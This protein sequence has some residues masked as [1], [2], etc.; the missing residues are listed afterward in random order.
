MAVWVI[1]L[2]ILITPCV[3]TLLTSMLDARKM[4]NKNYYAS[5][6]HF[7]K[8][9]SC[10]NDWTEE[11]TAATVSSKNKLQS[12]FGEKLFDRFSA[13]HLFW[14][15]L[16]RPGIAS[17]FY[18][19]TSIDQLLVVVLASNVDVIGVA[20]SK[21]KKKVSNSWDYLLQCYPL[22]EARVPER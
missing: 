22:R 6:L 9:W 4:V 10:P 11:I 18:F 21:R 1:E 12:S 15:H 7:V 3:S 5:I 8:W 14:S 17:L 19:W 16:T 13:R 20:V 2:F